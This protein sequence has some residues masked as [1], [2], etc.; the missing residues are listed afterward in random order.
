MLGFAWLAFEGG[1]VHIIDVPGHGRFV[2][3]MIAGTTGIDA[4]L[5]LVDAAKASSCRPWSHSPSLAIW[6]SVRADRH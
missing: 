1:I 2:W 4:V 5:L 6:T 3:T